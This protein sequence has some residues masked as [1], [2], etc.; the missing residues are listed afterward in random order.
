MRTLRGADAKRVRDLLE[1]QPILA[2]P[3]GNLGVALWLFVAAL[4]AGII[5]F[6]MW[7]RWGV[8][9]Q[10]QSIGV[11]G[12]TT[13][14]I[15]GLLVARSVVAIVGARRRRAPATWPTGRF[16]YPFGFVEARGPVF[17]VLPVEDFESSAITVD[18]G[19][20][21]VLQKVD[22]TFAGSPAE[23][24]HFA[25]LP[26]QTVAPRL[27]EL[28][29]CRDDVRAGREVER[30]Q[31]VAAGT[32][33]PRR[34][35]SKGRAWLVSLVAGLGVQG[36]MYVWWMPSKSVA[37]AEEW[38][39]PERWTAVE[40]AFPFGWVHDHAV[41][42]VSH[43]YD[44]LRAKLQANVHD[45]AAVTALMAAVDQ[46]AQR[47]SSKLGVSATIVDPGDFDAATKLVRDGAGSGAQDVA[48]VVLPRGVDHG[49]LTT[50][51]RGIV[52][53]TSLE[54]SVGDAEEPYIRIE[55]HLH[56]DGNAFQFNSKR[57]YVA[58]TVDADV[59]L[60]ANGKTYPLCPHSTI[61]PPSEMTTSQL[62]FEGGTTHPMDSFD[63]PLIYHQM[64]SR[65]LGQAVTACVQHAIRP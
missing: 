56:G 13:Y 47:N 32:P 7:R 64:V 9:S 39:Q 33:P 18:K 21:L 59:K 11:L 53:G 4:G 50:D 23:R 37:S 54:L 60:I 55:V 63:D 61:A 29:A 40:N 49:S 38:H 1:Q 10:W 58:L 17:R 31:L 34:P 20:Q 12:W 41:A 5:G 43:G 3:D 52:E 44:E 16:V 8:V 15:G 26:G 36:A 14:A 6:A 57:L 35:W 24:F 30:L 65:Q 62:V 42:A 45:P 25:T 27:S 19:D 46:L 2:E 22:V 51:L 28:E 48:P